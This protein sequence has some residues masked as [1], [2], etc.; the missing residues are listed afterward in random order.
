MGK[1]LI[2]TGLL[3]M[4]GPIGI[5]FFMSVFPHVLSQNTMLFWHYIL[6]F[7]WIIY[8][9]LGLFLLIFGLAFCFLVRNGSPESKTQT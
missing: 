4:F 8:V 3:V 2:A 5:V 1:W 7:C 9:P 6:V